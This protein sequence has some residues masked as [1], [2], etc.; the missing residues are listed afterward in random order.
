VIAFPI[1]D[2]A[3][4]WLE[5]I[6][7]ERFGHA[8]RLSRVDEGLRLRLAGAEGAILFDTMCEGF[9]QAHSDQPFTCWDTEREGWSSVLGGPLP[10]P[11]VAEL[12]SP[13]IEPQGAAQVIHYDILGLTYWMLARVEEIGRTDLDNHERFPATSSHAFKHG[14]LDRPVVDE[15]LHVLGQVIQRQWPGVE[16]KRH[17]FSIKMSHDVDQPSLY[18]F[19]PWRTI[20]RMMAGHILKRRDLEAFFTAP[21]VKLATRNELI[22]ADPYNTFDWLMDV[23]EAN[24]LQSAF[25]FICGRTNPA[26]DSDYEPEHPVI[27]QL[28]RHIHERG[29]EIGLHPSYDTFQSPTLLKQEADRLKRICAEEGI[30]QTQWGGRMH[31][32]RWEQPTT[33]RAWAEA[34]LDYDASMGYADHVGFRCGTAHEYKAFDSRKNCQ[35]NLKIRP[36][37]VM[38]TTISSQQYMSITS[39]HK[40]ASIIYDLNSKTERV[41]GNLELL[42]HNNSLHDD[43]IIKAMLKAL[44]SNDGTATK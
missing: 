8:W 41:V 43:F 21:Y 2:A 32:L 31:Y 15:W 33:L 44:M 9:T 17:E 18:A 24:N 13:L 1:T 14:Y 4:R 39:E 38:D 11:G 6:L 26:R 12:P 27:R 42:L 30:Q 19:K 35:Y 20:G 28:M 7:A 23:S 16:L 5:V 34:G 37:I 40:V 10:A 36:L 3:L 25:Y 22:T 29:H